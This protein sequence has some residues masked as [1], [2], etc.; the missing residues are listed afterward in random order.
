MNTDFHIHS[1]LSAD[2]D[3]PMED[4]IEQGIRLGL[5]VMCFT[6]HMDFG[7]ID[8]GMNFELDT[9]AYYKKY[10]EMKDRYAGRMK[11][12]FGIELGL[13]PHLAEKHR[14]YLAS[15]PF[16][17]CIGSSH[18]VDGMDPYYP[19]FYEGRSEE[20]C[21]RRYFASILENLDAF[22]D[23]DSYGHIDY[24][25][26]Y[27]PNKNA[28]YSYERY[29]DL[30]DEILKMLI[31]KDIALEV[32]TAGYKYGLGAPN[33]HPD[34]LKKYRSMGGELITIGSDAHRPEHLAYDF[35]TAVTL[36]RECGFKSYAVFEKR[37][38]HF[39]PL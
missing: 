39:L 35:S 5:S 7:Y 20:A 24:V 3:S 1:S 37:V 25:V 11:L 29:R 4:M 33:P 9:Q 23:V 13:Q 27:G 26:R 6:E 17:F 21:Y 38:P 22:S 10:L 15:Y 14:Q 18:L 8:E 32:N 16:D 19:K 28:H 36:L 31:E 12:L 2:S 34:I 30:I